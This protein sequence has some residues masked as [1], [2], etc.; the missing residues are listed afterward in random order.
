MSDD[1]RDLL[2]EAGSKPAP[3]PDP[4]FVDALDQRLRAVAAS[5]PQAA[6]AGDPA[7]DRS[8]SPRSDRSRRR[9]LTGAIGPLPSPAWWRSP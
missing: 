3:D 6:D 4:A 9:R 8:P 1:P 7:P 5:L 2:D